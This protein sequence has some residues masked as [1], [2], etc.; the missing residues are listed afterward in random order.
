MNSIILTHNDLDGLISAAIALKSLESKPKVIF[1]SNLKLNKN[2]FITLSKISDYNEI[3]FF[4]FGVREVLVKVS[5][6]LF[7]KV[8][9]IDHHVNEKILQFQNVEYVLD[10]KSES[11]A[12]LV[13]NYFD[14][15]SDW[16]DIVN[17]VDT[18]NCKTEISR[19]IRD[20]FT[21]IRIKYGKLYNRILSIK[22]KS[23]LDTNPRDFVNS[24]E[25]KKSLEEFEKIKNDFV[26]NLEESL[27]IVN[28]KNLKIAIVETKNNIPPFIVYE[29]VE[30]KN[31]NNDNI[32]LLVI[33]YRGLKGTKL[34][35]RSFGK[36]DVQKIAKHFNGGGHKMASG[37]YLTDS[38]TKSQILTKIEEIL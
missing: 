3:Y 37:A 28:L 4:D 22:V 18:N 30:N 23:I 24:E 35:F 26:K 20:Y 2:F 13:A 25:V 19:I 9:W 31:D 8:V 15:Y 7:K 14:F 38:L 17:E 16:V 5:A 27:E 6:T 32:D 29:F 12:K 21:S 1:S 36:V 11:A 33:V 34:E 10:E